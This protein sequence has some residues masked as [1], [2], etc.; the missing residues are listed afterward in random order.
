MV[1]GSSRFLNEINGKIDWSNINNKPTIPTVNNATL[2][3]QKNG[4]NVQ[5][6]T[7]N[8]STNVTANITVPTKV[9]ELTNDSGYT[10][11]V[12]TITGIK[13]NGAS[14]GTSG[15]VDLGTVITAHQD[16]SGKADKATTLSGYGITDAKIASG[17]ITL[18]SNTITPLTAS[19]TLD[20]TKLSGTIPSSCYTDTNN[21]V[22]QTVTDSTDATYELLFSD[23]ADNTTRTEGARKS[24]YATFNP[25]KQA[26]TFGVR[27]SGSTV[28]NYSHAEG[29]NTTASG[30]S[31]HAEGGSTTASGNASHAE[32]TTT[33][34]SSN[35]SHAE[36]KSTTASGEYSHAEGYRTTAIGRSSHAEGDDTTARGDYSHAEGFYATASGKDSHAEG[37]GTIANH[38]SQHVFGEYNIA[39]SSTA[40]SNDRGTYVEIVGNGNDFGSSARSNARTLDWDG[41]EWLAGTLTTDGLILK[42]EV[43]TAD[44]DD[45]L[46]QYSSAEYDNVDIG[47]S[48][49]NAK[50]AVLG[51]RSANHAN[52]PGGFSLYAKSSDGSYNLSGYTSTGN[53]YWTGHQFWLTGDE[54][55]I[56]IQRNGITINNTSNNGVTSDQIPG[57]ACVDSAG[58]AYSRILSGALTNGQTYISLQTFNKTTSGT[59]AFHNVFSVFANKD[60][61]RGYYVEDPS[62]FRSAISAF[63]SGGGTLTGAVSMQHTGANYISLNN[64]G[65]GSDCFIQMRRGTNAA[66]YYTRLYP[67]NGVNA[68]RTISF[69]NAGGTV[70]LASSDIRLKDNVKDSDVK[71]A[72]NIL[73]QIKIRQFDWK[74]RDDSDERKHQKIG[75][76]ADEME[77][78]DKNFVVEGS[79]GYHPDGE[80]NVKTVDTFYLL[81][82][83]VKAMQEMQ[84]EIEKLKK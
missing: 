62:T 63:S 45:F 59:S 72:M 3:I 39:D 13:M 58:F 47:W 19:S 80:I 36:G 52:N 12:G 31:S 37:L 79:G 21:A 67:Y 76:V 48:Y 77:L 74:D 17:T 55:M 56:D 44:N 10:S 11:N 83:M 22:T 50:G 66:T 38:K 75:F 27:K 26:F 32:G 34:A 41:N 69:P 68:N 1:S 23:T 73:N 84:K 40:E 35:S 28:G 51:L 57:I 24:K 25:S 64:A 71:N 82:Y 30:S 81:G 20:A 70:A 43:Y 65:T 33:T 2:T 46:M 7:A 5:T 15:N 49:S 9:S 78:I 60:G 14:K 18:G 29:Y 16:I 53:L 61:T 54:S 42:N 8:Q 4:T 6:F